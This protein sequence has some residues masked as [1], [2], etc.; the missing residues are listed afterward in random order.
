L[1]NK[2]KKNMFISSLIKKNYPRGKLD[3][4]LLE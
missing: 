2:D 3:D 1:N 4:K